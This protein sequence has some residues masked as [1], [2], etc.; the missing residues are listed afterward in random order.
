MTFGMEYPAR[1]GRLQLL[2]EA[3]TAAFMEPPAGKFVLFVLP[4][5]IFHHP[6]LFT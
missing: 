5:I 2:S 6:T 3:G 1:L 4:R